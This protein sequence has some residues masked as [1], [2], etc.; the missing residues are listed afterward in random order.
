MNHST[1]LIIIFSGF[2]YKIK[3]KAVRRQLFILKLK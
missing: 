3:K 1:T 2:E